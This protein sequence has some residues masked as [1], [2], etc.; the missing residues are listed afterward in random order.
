MGGGGET[1]RAG[2]CLTIEVEVEGITGLPGTFQA[3]GKTKK[4]KG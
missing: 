1:L 4:I 3:V 2:E